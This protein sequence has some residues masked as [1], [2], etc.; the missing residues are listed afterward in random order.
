MML[1]IRHIKLKM[2]HIKL[3]IR[4][5]KPHIRHIMLHI[6]HIKLHLMH[7]ILHIRTLEEKNRFF[8]IKI[9]IFVMRR[10]FL[11][12]DSRL[13]TPKKPDKWILEK[14]GL[15]QNI[16]PSLISEPCLRC[17]TANCAG[18][19]FCILGMVFICDR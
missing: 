1:N 19:I 15:F 13:Q 3:N 12:K 16:I 2:R 14:K 10:K 17:I 6:R 5:M 4:R 7:I 9:W 11:A 18:I 8:S